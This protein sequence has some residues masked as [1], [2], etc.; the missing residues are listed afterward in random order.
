MEQFDLEALMN[1]FDEAGFNR[2]IMICPDA[3]GISKQEAVIMLEQAESI[4]RAEN[5]NDDIRIHC[6]IQ[7]GGSMYVA[8][9]NENEMLTA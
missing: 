1:K 3:L 5:P 4:L 8:L 2:L 6:Y 9:I 7:D